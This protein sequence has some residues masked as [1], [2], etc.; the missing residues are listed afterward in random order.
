M[1]YS[2]KSPVISNSHSQNNIAGMQMMVVQKT[3]VEAI[4]WPK[5]VDS[6]SK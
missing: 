4:P 3:M 6:A 5:P 1:Y 2:L